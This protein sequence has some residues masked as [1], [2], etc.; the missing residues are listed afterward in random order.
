M[1]LVVM[2]C[3]CEK[4]RDDEANES[5]RRRWKDCQRYMTKYMLTRADIKFS[6]GYCP[7]CLASYRSFLGLPQGDV[8][9]TQKENKA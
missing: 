9:A 3:M 1:R 8:R 5:E 4:V 6:H 2:C 7:P